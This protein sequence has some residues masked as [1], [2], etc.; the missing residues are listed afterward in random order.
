MVELGLGCGHYESGNDRLPASVSG[1]SQ[2][3]P[4]AGGCVQRTEGDQF[5]VAVVAQIGDRAPHHVA[6]LLLR[7][8]GVV[9]AIR[10]PTVKVMSWSV[11]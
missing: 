3:I 5:L 7:E 10:T 1:R 9:L 2:R 4:L 6:V 11:Q 8:A